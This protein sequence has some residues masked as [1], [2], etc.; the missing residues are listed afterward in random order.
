[1]FWS[2]VCQRSSDQMRRRPRE[3][4]LRVYDAVSSSKGSLAIRKDGLHCDLQ[5]NQERGQAHLPDHEL[6]TVFVDLR[7]QG[8]EGK[9]PR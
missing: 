1:M 3:V 5:G 7:R 9:S 8:I 6:T 2:Q 4:V